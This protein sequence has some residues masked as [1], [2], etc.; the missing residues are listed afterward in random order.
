MK[1][2]LCLETKYRYS[3]VRCT[4]STDIKDDEWQFRCDQA[5]LLAADGGPW[6]WPTGGASCILLSLR[7]VLRGVPNCRISVYPIKSKL[8]KA[9]VKSLISL[10]SV[11]L[12]TEQV[13]EVLMNV[14]CVYSSFFVEIEEDIF[15]AFCLIAL[16]RSHCL[17]FRWTSKL[18][19]LSN[20]GVMWPTWPSLQGAMEGL[21]QLLIMMSS[22][23][24]ASCP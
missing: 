7:K 24:Q 3:I 16:L 12:I 2:K 9:E 6:T 15:L 18:P 22:P 13:V 20:S 4:I 23:S 11:C 8:S 19:P 21:T 5:P 10:E 17:Y 1:N 14:V